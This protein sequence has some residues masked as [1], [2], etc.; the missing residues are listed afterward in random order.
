MYRRSIHFSALG[1]KIKIVLVAESYCYSTSTRTA[2]VNAPGERER[3]EGVPL[4]M[5]SAAV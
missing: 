1:M 4:C 5:D 2:F 3:A